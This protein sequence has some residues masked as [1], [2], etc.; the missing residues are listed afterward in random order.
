MFLIKLHRRAT[1]INN[2]FNNL[3][4]RASDPN[5]VTFNYFDED[6]IGQDLHPEGN[7]TPGCVSLYN[8]QALTPLPPYPNPTVN[9]THIKF[10]RAPTDHIFRH[11]L[12]RQ[13][14]FPDPIVKSFR[15]TEPIRDT[16]FDTVLRALQT[17]ESSHNETHT[18]KSNILNEDKTALSQFRH[19]HP[20]FDTYSQIFQTYYRELNNN[21]IHQYLPYAAHIHAILQFSMIISREIFIDQPTHSHAS[22][23]HEDF[24]TRLQEIIESWWG[25]FLHL[26]HMYDC[27]DLITVHETASTS[28]PS[29]TIELHNDPIAPYL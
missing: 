6:I 18:I 25:N 1:S 17:I 10:L 19:K 5:Q 11:T 21:Y 28:S 9:E 20:Y 15:L 24:E 3:C 27:L 2:R 29:S 8:D 23:F 16:T 7:R 26:E 4:N 13:A 22:W 14:E 12:P